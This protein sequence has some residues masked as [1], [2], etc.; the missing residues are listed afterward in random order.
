VTWVAQAF[1]LVVM[2]TAGEHVDHGHHAAGPA[3]TRH[4]RD[5]SRCSLDVVKREA[6][7]D[8]VELIG[9]ERES[10]RVSPHE[11]YAATVFV[12]HGTQ[13]SC[14]HRVCQVDDHCCGTFARQVPAKLAGTPGYIEYPSARG[15]RDMR[16]DPVKDRCVAEQRARR[17][18]T[19]GLSTELAS[20]DFVL[21]AC[22]AHNDHCDVAGSTTGGSAGAK[23]A[24]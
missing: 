9:G 15:D 12:E 16:G 11:H 13:P 14:E 7:H 22:L 20:N 10:G 3:Y 18:E 23:M 1:E 19:R 24:A 2:F 17:L 5:R 8:D 4:L 6:A 21:L